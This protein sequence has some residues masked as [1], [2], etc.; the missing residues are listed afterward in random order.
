M[1]VTV[2]GASG[3]VGQRVVERL[4]VDGH[5]VVAFVHSSAPFAENDKL[6]VVTGDVHDAV[7]AGQ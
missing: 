1:Q 6:K 2:F 4:L 3:N 7:A 5:E